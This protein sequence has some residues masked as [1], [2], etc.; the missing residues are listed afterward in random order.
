LKLPDFGPSNEH[1]LAIAVIV[2]SL[3]FQSRPY[4]VGIEDVIAALNFEMSKT[5]GEFLEKYL[6]WRMDHPIVK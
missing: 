5:D 6:R 3:D 2:D 1:E 4:S